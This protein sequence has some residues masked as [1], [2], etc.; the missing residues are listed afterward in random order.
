MD[1]GQ[2]ATY[3][4]P[5]IIRRFLSFLVCVVIV[6]A[7][8][9]AL[10]TY[11]L[12]PYSVPSGSME[13]TIMTGDRIFAEKVSY[14][15]SEPVAGDIVVFSDPQT[16]SRTLVKRVIATEGQTVD[17]ID[18]VV[19]VDGVALD[20]SY[21]QGSSYPLTN[22]IVSIS[23]PYTVPEGEL[24]VM[25]DN[26]QHSSDSRYFG[27]IEVSSVIGKA[28]LVYWPLGSIGLLE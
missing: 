13:S 9:F 16:P 15:F 10:R 23:Y 4:E 26:R 3:R 6:V 8:V 25:G 2:H 22:A 12:E 7:A 21:V 11:V 18:G 19:Y 17:L 28:V 27:S 14:N 1:S 20:E 5:G 24:W